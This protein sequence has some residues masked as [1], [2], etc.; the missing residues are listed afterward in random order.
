MR[1]LIAIP[2]MAGLLGMAALAAPLAAQ[3]STADTPV[4]FNLGAGSLSIQEPSSAT[5]SATVGNA[6][7]QSE[8]GTVT[9]VDDTGNPAGGWDATAVAGDFT[10]ETN[11]VVIPSSA[12]SYN[13]GTIS[14]DTSVG[15]FTPAGL[16][17][18][19]TPTGEAPAATVVTAADETG[20]ATVSWDPTV[21]IALPSSGVVAD[22]YDGTITESVA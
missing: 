2:I 21:T 18:I 3:A 10:G 20:N 6:S 12:V 22:T 1:K 14:G 17:N 15:T 7:A 4:T 5:L 13:A 8:L 19:G 9:V 11:G 16:V